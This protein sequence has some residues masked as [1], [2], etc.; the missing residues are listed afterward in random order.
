MSDSDATTTPTPNAMPGAADAVTTALFG[1]DTTDHSLT[2]G[3]S[4][5]ATDGDATADTP[6]VDGIAAERDKWKR[7]AQTNEKRAKANADKAKAYDADFEKFKAAYEREQQRTNDTQDDEYTEADEVALRAAD[8]ESR[9]A[10]AEAK[11]LRFKLADGVP[12]WA[13]GLITGETEEDIEAQV[14]TLK[15]NLAAYTASAT[16]PRRP[17]PNPIAGRGGQLG[18]SPKEDFASA[19]SSILR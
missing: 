17:A 2:E 9:A 3:D 8:A 18:N 11:L 16:E 19:F 10:E 5:D 6:D 7:Q 15:E 1:G 12:E 4:A 14:D 13:L